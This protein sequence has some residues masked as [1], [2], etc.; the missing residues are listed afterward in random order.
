MG[1]SGGEEFEF[2]PNFLWQ[3]S[4]GTMKIT[5]TK[6]DVAEQAL[7]AGYLVI[8]IMAPQPNPE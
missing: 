3:W 4:D 5:T 8:G 2:M 6:V 7:R 1:T